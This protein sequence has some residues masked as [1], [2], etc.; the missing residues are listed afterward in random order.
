MALACPAPGPDIGLVRGLIGTVDCNVGTLT[1]EGYGLLSGPGSTV[2]AVLLTLMTLYVAF[3]GYRMLLGRTP[4][5]VGE[6]TVSA[7]K[8]GVVLALA[9]NWAAY[10]T[11]VY[12]TLFRGPAQLAGMLLSAVQ[13]ATSILRGDPF[14]GLQ[15]VFDELQR[16]SA[17][18][19][20]RAG[21][22]ASPF[23]G[24]V[25]FGAFAL[26]SSAFILLLSSL[27]VVLAS[28]IVLAVL[29]AM[30]PLV[31]GM[32]LFDATRAMVEGWLKTAVAFSLAPFLATLFLALQL[33]MLEPTLVALATMRAEGR[34]DL[35]PAVGILVLTTVF[36]V[37]LAGAGIAAVMLAAGIRLPRKAAGADAAEATRPAAAGAPGATAATETQTRVAAVAAA[38]AAM[39]RRETG[40]ARASL[41]VASERRITV[42]R[43][44][45]SAAAAGPSVTTI[46]P[47][48][49]SYRRASAPLRSATASRRDR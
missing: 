40:V 23:M 35:A 22:Q 39:E 8:V 21:A 11:V 24:G 14:D 20:G 43:E 28:K 32:L 42:G 26:N 46:Q 3:I 49:Q 13:P 37:V 33:T 10:Q 18:F 2:M 25:G 5:R 44:R 17:T 29:L 41:S 30:A 6:V 48:G 38:A 7:L 34:A 16:S 36:L 31:A 27:G 45:H 15:I 12:D 9:S 4:M 19:A 47:L 1:R